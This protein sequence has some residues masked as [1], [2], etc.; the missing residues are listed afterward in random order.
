[1]S[2]RVYRSGQDEPIRVAAAPGAA[3]RP[4]TRGAAVPAAP[5]RAGL[6]SLLLWTL[7]AC[8]ASCAAVLAWR[9]GPEMYDNSLAG[10]DLARLS[11]KVPG[12]VLYAAPIVAILVAA[13]VAL[14]LAIGR[15]VVVK[16]LGVIVVVLAVGAPGFAVGWANGNIAV[17][18][19]GSKEKASTVTSTKKELK[20]ELPG[21]AVNILLIGRDLSAPGDPGRSDTQMLVRLDP[22]TKSISMLSIP[23]DLYV[24]IPGVGFDKMNAAF[25]YGGAALVVKTFTQ[26]TGLPIN[27]FVEI[28]FAGFW[29]VVNILGGVYVSIDH[30]YYN[31]EGHGYQPINIEPGYQLV[32]GKDAL[33]FVRFRHDQQSDFTRMQRQQLFLKELQRQSS[34]W[35]GD[36]SRVLR[37][38]KAIEE[39]STSDI[40]SLRSL[41]KL[42]RLVFTVDTSKVN[43]VHLEGDTPTMSGVSYVTATPE[44]IAAAVSEFT[45][46]QQA[47]VKKTAPKIANTMFPVAVHNTTMTSG[48]ATSVAGQLSN[49]GYETSIGEDAPESASTSTVIY[50]PTDLSAA[51]QTLS[52]LLAP[53]VVHIVGRA[54][55]LADGIQVFVGSQ[56]DGTIVIPSTSTTTQTALTIQQGQSYDLAGWQQL[57]AQTPIKLLMPTVWSSSLRYDEMRAYKVETTGGKMSQAAIAVGV[58]PSG[59]YFGIQAMR[60]LHPPAIE[61]PDANRTIAGTKY[62]YF[63]QGQHL[64]MLAWRAGNTLYWV[65]NTLDNELDN[66]F[67]TALATSFTRVK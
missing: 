51:A 26:V 23:R 43:A 56:F 31:T 57:D 21:K 33:A 3:R 2:Y 61:H 59:G 55:G 36:W 60:W 54:P 12:W 27:H 10:V 4:S 8:A 50:A 16:T 42:V 39:Q 65:V 62:M 63:Y 53:A 38:I 5:T 11:G 52:T 15:H 32:H 13:L 17:V 46:P 67:M 6:R 41:S 28:D 30:R 1:M 48:L 40:D 29:H 25:S 47:P 37:L 22:V 58:A 34:R 20:G 64:H 19:G 9:Y 14:Y 35:S 49:A 44:Q 18:S 7:L 66:D 24:D 45:N